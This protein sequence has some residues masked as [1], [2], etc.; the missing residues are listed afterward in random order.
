M[1]KRILGLALALIMIISLLPMTALAAD[2]TPMPKVNIVDPSYTESTGHYAFTGGITGSNTLYLAFEDVMDATDPTVRLGNK[3]VVVTE[4]PADNYITIFY[5]TSTNTLEVTLKNVTYNR[6]EADEAFFSC[7]ANN[8]ST[9][10]NNEYDVL[11]TLEGTNTVTGSGAGFNFGNKGSLTITG[12]GSLNMTT[13]HSGSSKGANLNKTSAGEMIIKD[14]TLNLENTYTDSSTAVIVNNGSVT[15]DN[16]KVSLIPGKARGIVT[17][18][19]YNEKPTDTTHVVTIKNNAELTSIATGSAIQIRTAGKIVINNASVELVKST[20][21]KDCF[22]S[23]LPYLEGTFSS[24]QMLKNTGKSPEYKDIST[25]EVAEGTAINKDDHMFTSYKVVHEHKADATSNDC[26]AGTLCACGYQMTPGTAGH[27]GVVTDCTKDTMCTNEGCT[28]VYKAA[29]AE[30]VAGE[31]DGDCTT[32]VKCAN[33]DQI[34]IEAKAHIG[35]T[36]TCT[37]L[38][39]CETCGK[40][41]GELAAH[42]VS[43]PDCSVEGVCSVCTQ[44]IYQAGQHSGG[45]ATCK[46]LAKCEFC[47]KEYGELAAHTGGTATCKELAKCTVCGKEYGE[48]A[49]CVAEADDGNCTTA[50]KCSVCG[51]ELTAAK[52][53]HKYTDNKDTTCDNEGCTNVRKIEAAGSENDNPKTADNTALVLFAALMVASAAAFVCT[54]KFAVR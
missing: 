12:S 6:T 46:E 51:K 10:Y 50:I 33:C 30:H 54:K 49:A 45:T 34:V 18:A 22:A 21:T 52:D 32:P 38:A 23:T 31:D 8:P 16:A 43:R 37:A 42:T 20:S 3:P 25:F 44:V 48:L 28:K 2:L 47:G 41:Y 24:A 11:M 29:V 27:T 26:T 36:A 13:K 9:K 1:K 39:K 4:A 7:S 40:E 53:A 17:S 19:K 14:V 15:I 5:N 35:G